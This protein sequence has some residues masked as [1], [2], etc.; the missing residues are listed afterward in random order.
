GEIPRVSSRQ[1]ALT[2]AE[3][4]LLDVHRE[5]VAWLLYKACQRAVAENRSAAIPIHRCITD[6]CRL[7]VMPRADQERRTAIFR[8]FDEAPAHRGRT[9]SL[10]S[11]LRE[12]LEARQHSPRGL[13]TLS[14]R[15][16]PHDSTRIWLAL[17]M[18]QDRLFSAGMTILAQV[19]HNCSTPMNAYAAW[20]NQGLALWRTGNLEEASRAYE[21][22]AAQG[23]PSVIP[24][25]YRLSLALLM[26]DPQ[27]ALL[28]SERIHVLAGGGEEGLEE[29]VRYLQAMQSTP[30]GAAG[31]ECRTIARRVQELHPST[32]GRIAGVYL[33]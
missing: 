15:L 3:R 32:A 33:P 19:L 23:E 24:V 20:T 27:N 4:H 21:E 30:E 31:R 1:A 9:P 11:V 5:E 13:A 8:Q 22:A 16:V 6:L 28:L 10:P 25:V 18:M 29:S 2:A 14:L 17:A 26:G 7:E 12:D